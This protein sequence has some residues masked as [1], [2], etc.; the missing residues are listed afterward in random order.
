MME[1]GDDTLTSKMG[2]QFY[3][4]PEMFQR[5]SFRGIPADIWACGVVLFQMVCRKSLP[6]NS[7]D[8]PNLQKIILNEEP[9][10]SKISD[11]L[12]VHLL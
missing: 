3:M 4:C 1:N 8:L 5:T 6:F 12:L 9:D 2:T 11:S 10:Y 7:D